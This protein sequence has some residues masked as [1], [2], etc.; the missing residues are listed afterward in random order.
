M[1]HEVRVIGPGL[2]QGDVHGYVFGR[3]GRRQG[4]QYFGILIQPQKRRKTEPGTFERHPGVF[5]RIA[6][7][8]SVKFKRQ[9]V[10]LG[11]GLNLKPT[12]SGQ[13]ESVGRCQIADRKT[14][15]LLSQSEVK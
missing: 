2:I 11:Y 5:K 4:N 13:I 1:L 12:L 6:C 8:Y 15:F 14:V 3:G 10:G 9:Q 7:V